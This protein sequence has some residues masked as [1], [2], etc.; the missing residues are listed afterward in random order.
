[1][2]SL[3]ISCS[4]TFVGSPSQRTNVASGHSDA[5]PVASYD[6]DYTG[7]GAGDISTPR[8]GTSN[9]GTTPSQ[10]PLLGDSCRAMM[11]TAH[12]AAG[13]SI[14]SSAKDDRYGYG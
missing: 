9:S 13:Q 1:M 6:L 7:K 4:P 14:G 3:F 10:G 2:P 12:A 11:F 8:R 5:V